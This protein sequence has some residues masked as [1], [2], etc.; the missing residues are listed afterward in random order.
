MTLEQYNVIKTKRK[1]Q[2]DFVLYITDKRFGYEGEKK[3]RRSWLLGTLFM[4]WI[5]VAIILF[6]DVENLDAALWAIFLLIGLILIIQLA[7]LVVSGF[8]QKAICVSFSSRQLIVKEEVVMKR[9]FRKEMITQTEI[10]LG[11]ITAV[12]YVPLQSAHNTPN[13]CVQIDFL[14]RDSMLLSFKLNQME[15]RKVASLLESWREE[16]STAEQIDPEQEIQRL[17]AEHKDAK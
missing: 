3:G 5:V 8:M 4:I 14:K 2:A 9:P 11:E 12:G 15:A 10:G 16:L 6:R 17:K 7:G 13:H 1:D